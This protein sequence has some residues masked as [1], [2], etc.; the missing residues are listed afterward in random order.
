MLLILVCSLLNHL[1]PKKVDDVMKLLV[2]K[3]GNSKGV[4]LPAV[5]LKDLNVELGDKLD[6]SNQSGVWVIEPAKPKSYSLDELLAK[7][8]FDAPMPKELEEW[9]QINPIGNE[10]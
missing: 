2:R 1:T 10:I 4:V 5:L 7:C 9:E 6:I 8:D 3:I